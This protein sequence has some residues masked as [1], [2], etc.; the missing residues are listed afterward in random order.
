[1]KALAPTG[2]VLFI[3]M[4]FAAPVLARQHKIMSLCEIHYPSDVNIEWECL[5]LKWKDTPLALFGEHWQD[6]LRFN[7]LDRR[8]FLGGRSIKVPKRLEDIKGFTPLPATYPDAAND[9][10]FILVDQS[11]M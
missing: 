8:H 2:F 4:L 6:V 1:M 3:F 7:R 5:K 9:E 11:E 10:K